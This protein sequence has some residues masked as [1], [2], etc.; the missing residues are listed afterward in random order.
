M[1]CIST[2]CYTRVNNEST[3]V[4]SACHAA[5]YAVVSTLAPRPTVGVQA[6]SHTNFLIVRLGSAYLSCRLSRAVSRRGSCW[7]PTPSRRSETITDA[8]TP[9]LQILARSEHPQHSALDVVPGGARVFV[10]AERVGTLLC[11]GTAC[12]QERQMTAVL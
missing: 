6:V 10:P 8:A 4:S 11:H 1:S 2:S 7:Q 9:T 5:V 12:R 3:D